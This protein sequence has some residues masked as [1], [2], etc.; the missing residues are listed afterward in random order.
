MS[1]AT[2]A[3]VPAS[4]TVASSAFALASKSQTRSFVTAQAGSAGFSA[5][6]V[7]L[8][9]NVIADDGYVI[10]QYAKQYGITTIFLDVA[11][12]DVGLLASQDPQESANLNAMLDVASVYIV[13]GDASWLSTPAAVP[14]DVTTIVHTIAPAFPRLA[15]ILY[16]VE[17]TSTQTAAYF[18]LLD[19]LLGGSK[20]YA[21]G[22]TL[23]ETSPSWQRWLNRTGGKTPSMLQQ[24]ESYSAVS[25]TYLL[26]NGG[27]ASLQMTNDVDKA[28]PQL[29]K[30]Y[31]SGANA[32]SPSG[33]SYLGQTA[34]YVT[35]NMQQ[36][37]A[38]VSAINAK[39]AGISVGAWQDRYGSLQT[40]FAQPFPAA[41]PAPSAPLVPPPGQLYLGA[42]VNP[43]S[44][45]GAGGGATGVAAFES[46]IGR[47]LA[48][49]LHF[50]GWTSAFPAS[51]LNDD[52]TNGRVPLVAL[53]CG[54]SDA[55]VASGADDS[56][57]EAQASAAAAY[58][59]PIF[60]RYFW[61]FNLPASTKRG[62]CYDSATDLPNGKFSPTNFKAAWR[63]MHDLYVAAGAK[64]VI[65]VWNE[66]GGG[67]TPAEYYPGDDVVDWVGVDY[68]DRIDIPF[69]TNE[70]PYLNDVAQ[71][72]KPIMI[73]ETAA[74]ADYQAQY[75]PQI[76]A[77]L[78]SNYGLVKAVSFF[79]GLGSVTGGDWSLTTTGVSA[80][81][82]MARQSAYSPFAPAQ[83]VKR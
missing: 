5:M 64:N 19:T 47:K 18:Q 1:A 74:N 52:A 54:D 41:V 14:S 68:Y 26:M 63:H 32:Y 31:W 27:S 61:E 9:K 62:V 58:G 49:D 59:K 40:I 6:T 35:S 10:A 67:P 79:D 48:Y 15:G 21:F 24:A 75:F 51:V 34:S 37:S 8:S 17:P 70:S 82:N 20:P 11:G 55:R 57:I 25:G 45:P 16:D 56:A 43:T 13:T 81:S 69:V 80:F 72:K 33:N 46:A 4:A 36:V 38:D 53:D 2:P 50:T 29:A 3:A 71:Y 28:L 73:C 23:L 83:S 42:Y 65:W 44:G 66:S 60:L 12:D 76:A 77:A 22:K 30:P 7:T 78:P 39:L